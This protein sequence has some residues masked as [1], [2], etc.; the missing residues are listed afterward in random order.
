MS[1]LVTG[2]RNSPLTAGIDSRRLETIEGG[3]DVK[4]ARRS[5]RGVFRT[6]ALAGVAVAILGFGAD[7]ASAVRPKVVKAT[8]FNGIKKIAKL[9]VQGAYYTD[10]S[11]RAVSRKLGQP[12]RVK[13]NYETCTSYYYGSGLTLLFTTF[14]TYNSCRDKYLQF[15][16]VW[17]RSW[18]VKVGHRT[19]RV[20]MPIRQTPGRKKYSP[21]FGYRVASMPF[22]G[23]RSGTVFLRFNKRNRV[24]SIYLFI[25]GAGD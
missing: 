22:V 9:N 15:A 21:G 3:M 14:G 13:A 11:F 1:L 12:G 10:L 23:G 18:R 6:V 20:G 16:T 25:G 5:G 7:S 8:K 24:S 17:K 4:S 19:Y 2:D